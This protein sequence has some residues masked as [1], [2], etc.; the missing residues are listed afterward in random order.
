[1]RTPAGVECAFY[2]EDHHRGR[3]LSECRVLRSPRSAAWSEAD[4]PRCPV[5]GI[6]LANGSPYLE[7]EL[8]VRRGL[9]GLGA[10]TS[11]AAR[12]RRHDRVI[13]DPYAGCSSCAAEMLSGVDV[14]GTATGIDPSGDSSPASD[15]GPDGEAD[16]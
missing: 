9:F 12:C 3:A 15:P 7:L 10:R 6:L 4:C 16:V 1:M 5:P 13:E 2:Y 11:V 8:T 14:E